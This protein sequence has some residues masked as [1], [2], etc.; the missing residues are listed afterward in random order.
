MVVNILAASRTNLELYKEIRGKKAATGLDTMEFQSK[1]ETK[2]KAKNEAIRKA[3][4]EDPEAEVKTKLLP[5][6]RKA[7]E[8]TKR[9]LLTHGETKHVVEGTEYD[10]PS[11][12]AKSRRSVK[13][14]AVD[15]VPRHKHVLTKK[16]DREKLMSPPKAIPTA[17]GHLP[18]HTGEHHKGTTSSSMIPRA[19]ASPRSPNLS[20]D[21]KIRSPHS[22]SNDS[23]KR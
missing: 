11:L 23:S 3:A 6:G 16:L 19:G 7:T 12:H 21:R 9:A 22:S 14:S 13:S 10:V 18:A 8:I 1:V 5:S 20:Q 17:T 4:M 2:K 15:A